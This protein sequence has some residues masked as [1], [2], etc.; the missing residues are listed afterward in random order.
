MVGFFNTKTPEPTG[1]E[2]MFYGVPT[3]SK[4]ASKWQ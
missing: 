3:A 1:L 2:P 4:I